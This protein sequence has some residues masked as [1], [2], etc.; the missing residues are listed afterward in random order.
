MKRKRQPD[1]ETR[2][3]SHLL[4]GCAAGA[5]T[6]KRS[7]FGWFVAAALVAALAHEA[8]DAPVAQVLT[9]LGM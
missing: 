3:V 8:L 9:D 4:V 7:G 5:A 2:F 6:G 1:P